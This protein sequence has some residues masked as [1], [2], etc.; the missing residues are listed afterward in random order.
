MQMKVIDVLGAKYTIR[1]ESADKDPFLKDCD[2]YTDKTTRQI[3]V[4][5]AGPDNELG[6]FSVYYKKVLRHEI[7]HA[8]LFESGLHESWKHEEG[9]DEA[10]VDWIAVQAPKLIRA[11]QE[12]DA[13]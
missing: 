1:V 13:L 3:V 2:G 4:A 10:Y 5:C 7:I 12:A 8:F 9:H 6:A 11:F